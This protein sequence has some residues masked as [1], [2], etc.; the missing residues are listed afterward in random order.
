MKENVI[1]TEA[2][3]KH[4]RIFD[5]TTPL[6][7]CA[8]CRVSTD[9]ADQ[10]NSF[11]S[12]RN[13][14]NRELESHQNWK[15]GEIFADEGISGT[16]LRKRDEF[17]RMIQL[18]REGV[19]DLI[20]TKEVSRFS[21]N[22]QDLLNIVE[23]L[24]N[25][26]VYIWFM[27]EDINTENS[28][29]RQ[30]ITEAGRQAENE[31]L[32]TSRRVLW[33]QR[34][35]MENGVVFGRKEM[36]GYN[37][38]R[39]KSGKQHFEIIE[40]EA[41]IVRRIFQMYADG[42]GTFKIARKLENEGIPTKRKGST[43][44]NTVILR[45]LRNE[46]YVGDLTTGKTYT[47]DPLTHSKK[48]NRGESVRIEYPGHHPESAIISRELWNRVASLLAEN[49]PSAEQKEKHSSRYW[50]SGKVICGECGQ[51]YVSH[52]KHLKCGNIYKC[53][54]CWESQQHGQK[55]AK[56]LE[57][58]E[59]I[60][61][62]CDSESVNDATL[63]L[64][65]HD[66]LLVCIKPEIDRL[67]KE[68]E[69]SYSLKSSTKVSSIDKQ[70]RALKKKVEKINQTL[71]NL[72]IKF[73]NGEIEKNI[74]QMAQE[75]QGDELKKIQAQITDLTRQNYD[76]INLA[77]Q[78]DQQISWLK[79]I[80]SLEDDKFNEEL[81]GR[82]VEKIVVYNGHILEFY[83]YPLKKPIKLFYQT[84]GRLNSFTADFTILNDDGTPA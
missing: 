45:I 80:V 82:L 17:N 77:T 56:M 52:I 30:R 20:I 25:R 62:G 3:E 12:Q 67:C 9:K 69:E 40:E 4:Y 10:R 13:F 59:Q 83:F 24:R 58:G 74:Y 81:F 15:I 48:Y 27:T 19:F 31:S 68:L 8:Y 18:A 26:K 14:F 60:Q 49:A 2:A 43:W 61:T 33:G 71:V 79:E 42:Y 28:D 72:S 36:Y 57:N 38:A 66:I 37:I 32:K 7:V 53:W 63:R 50:C 73:S 22:I 46:K 78:K 65:V 35:Q 5:T 23:D 47:P 70:I 29:Y 1:I 21:R 75:Q 34:R 11:E 41:E 44:S 54:K 76:H 84:H 51:R 16:S 55:K 39:D 6:N 64:A